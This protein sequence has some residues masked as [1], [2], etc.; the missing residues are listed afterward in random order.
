M[1]TAVLIL[2]PGWTYPVKRIAEWSTSVTVAVSGKETTALFWSYPKWHW[3]V[4]IEV[5]R[6]SGAYA[7]AAALLNFYSGQR[8]RGR[9]FLFAD[10]EDNAVAGQALGVGDGVTTTFQLVRALGGP[11]GFVEP[12]WA[13]NVVSAVQ[14]GGVAQGAGWTVSGWGSAAPGTI[15]FAVAPAAG[16]AVSADFSF[17]F[18]C[19]FEEDKLDTQRFASGY[20]SVASLKLYSIK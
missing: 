18:V 17:Y 16:V 3:D 14:L 7:A 8:G 11:G 4:P 9:V 13:P 6:S 5:M 10:P 2:P 19:R 20:S 12:I 15:S 1:S